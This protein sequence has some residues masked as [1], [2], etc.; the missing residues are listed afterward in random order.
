MPL[1]R[2]ASLADIPAGEM[3]EATVAGVPYAVCNVDGELHA[4]LG[5]C[6]HQGGPL[7]QGA[8]HENMVVCPWH[9]WEFD[10]RTGRNDFDL[11][12]SVATA[13]VVMQGDDV[14]LDVSDAGTA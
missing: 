13:P 8:L 10:C 11:E 7:A 14:F 6:P 4:L 12:V 3:M 2:I 9:A 1:I 5:I